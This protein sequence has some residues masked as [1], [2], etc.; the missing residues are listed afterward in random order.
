MVCLPK[1]QIALAEGLKRFWKTPV[2]APWPGRAGPNQR[3]VRIG[4]RDRGEAVTMLMPGKMFDAARL[5][6][7][8]V[9]RRDRVEASAARLRAARRSGELRRRKRLVDRAVGLLP[10]EAENFGD[11]QV[12]LHDLRVTEGD[13]LAA[14]VQM[15][16]KTRDLE[17]A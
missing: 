17:Y 2:Y 8:Q 6:I 15:L 7:V 1:V 14:G 3:A 13:H 4:R 11:A 16:R 5:L 12:G 10:D 9:G